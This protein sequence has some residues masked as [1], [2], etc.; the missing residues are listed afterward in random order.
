[1][2]S[3]RNDGVWLTV[4]FSSSPG[5]GLPG[6]RARIVMLATKEQKGLAIWYS[7]IAAKFEF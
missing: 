3:I 6:N 7:S 4:W 5:F 1:M 2:P